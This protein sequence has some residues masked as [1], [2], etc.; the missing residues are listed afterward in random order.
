[1]LQTIIK[2]AECLQRDIGVGQSFTLEQ[3]SNAVEAVSPIDEVIYVGFDVPDTNPIWGQFWKYGRVPTAYASRT[4]TAEIK[5]AK[6]LSVPWR[7][8][9]VCKELCH[10]L[11]SDEGTHSISDRS[12]TRILS[13]FSLISANK[14]LNGITPAFNAE[15]LAEVGALELMCPIAT[16]QEVLK[17]GNKD[18]KKLCQ[19]FG[20]PEEFGDF[21]FSAAIT[22]FINSF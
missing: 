12:V 9:V 16:R 4:T 13:N 21:A 8:F 5:Y 10:A 15:M 7:R 1:M 20:I 18:V 11:E 22:D 14:K 2:I 17:G 19:Q 6:H 3:I